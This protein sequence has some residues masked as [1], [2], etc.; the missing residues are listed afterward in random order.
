MCIRDSYGNVAKTVAPKREKLKN[1]MMSLE[2]KQA[3][4]KK[5]QTELQAVVDKVQELQ[6][7]YDTSIA[8][9]DRLTNESATLTKKL[10]RADQLVNG[11]SGERARWE[12][13]LENLNKDI[14]NRSLLCRHMLLAS[15]S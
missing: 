7:K 6:S 3:A 9:K 4:L 5:A 1:A 8:T 11:L 15:C 10:E 14:E 2:K 13:S 12:G